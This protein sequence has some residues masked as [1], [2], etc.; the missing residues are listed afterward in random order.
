MNG[1]LSSS[2]QQKHSR[3][4]VQ[5]IRE[6][7]PILRRLVYGKPLVYLDNAATTQKPRSVIEA[8][9][10]YYEHTNANI[11]RG[12]HFLSERATE[13]YE[14]VR[15]K[16][17]KFLNAGDRCEIVFTRGTT[18][19]INLVASSLGRL[20][21]KAGDEVVLT[22]M[23]HHSNIVPWQ[24]ICSATG[25]KIRVAPVNDDGELCLDAFERLLNPKTKIVALTH[26][27]NALGTV[28]PVQQVVRMAKAV[29]A[30]VVVDGAQAVSHLAVDV[31][32]LGCDF[33]AFSG[34]KLFGPTGVGVLWGRAEL[35]DAMPPYQGGGE[36]I[37]TVRFE[38]ST[39]AKI[40]HKFE[41]GTP[42]IAEVIGLGAAVDYVLHVGYAAI[43]EHES[44]LR[45]G[46]T[47]T[48]SSIPGVRIIGNAH[49][50]AA[51]ISF[52]LEGVHPHD[53]G[54]IL[55]REGIA[56]RA[57][58]HCAQPLMER[59]GIAATARASFAFYNTRAEVDALAAGVQKVIEV[60]S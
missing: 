43:A 30:T 9:S 48:L 15:S 54:T 18:E 27:S 59:F 47:R 21:L 6:D 19:S 34:H 55:D 46:A 52:V 14:A 22:T 2:T 29:H 17:T 20:L 16:I 39:W 40:P 53:I 25:A 26:V 44:A 57:G 7:F 60:F 12:L 42:P 33:Y 58:H 36:M 4:D 45:D 5:R 37:R 31:Q 1:L 23:E 35:L 28:N 38:S 24:L 13:Q 56:I 3:L 50:K 49:D 51:V 11:H 32:Q 8:M 41:A 10:S